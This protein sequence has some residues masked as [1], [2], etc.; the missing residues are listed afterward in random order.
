MYKHFDYYMKKAIVTCLLV[1]AFRFSAA[2]QVLISWH[3]MLPDHFVIDDIWN[4]SISKSNSVVLDCQLE[5][6]I[7][8]NS[9]I[10]VMSM[11][12]GRLKIQ[13][14]MINLGQLRACARTSIEY[15]NNNFSATL[16]Q[17]GSLPMGDYIF[18]ATVT[19]ANDFTLLAVNCEE[20]SLQGV[21]APYLM[22]PYN[23][24]VIKTKN[25][26]LIWHGP[27]PENASRISY[28]LVLAM[29]NSNQQPEQAI[30][31]NLPLLNIENLSGTI[32]EYSTL[33]PPLEVGNTYA[34]KV[35]VYYDRQFF[36]STETWMFTV[37]DIDTLTNQPVDGS[38][39]L[40]NES[41]ADGFYLA[42]EFFRIGYD[43]RAN[44]PIL[45]YRIID[46]DTRKEISFHEEIPLHHG[47]NMISLD[48]RKDGFKE[49]TPYLLLVQD[50]N[51]KRYQS[52]FYYIKS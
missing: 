39:Q 45:K 36:G 3:T 2:A 9:H 13:Q 41:R 5:V 17:T 10:P 24:A 6:R 15:G 38:Y 22:A 49:S 50:S 14:Q 34:W 19:A 27:T 25:P 31:N 20:R 26:L 33:Y 21:S 30:L 29:V 32:L 44:D 51:G 4:L 23:E 11:A 7:E 8:T 18:C 52:I 12:I 37:A 42:S 16:Q 35:Q 1:I 47:I 46:T 28:Q 40:I 43:N 48:L